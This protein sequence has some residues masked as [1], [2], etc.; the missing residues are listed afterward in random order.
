MFFLRLLAGRNCAA[1][2]FKSYQ[3]SAQ[4]WSLAQSLSFSKNY[5]VPWTS[6]YRCICIRSHTHQNFIFRCKAKPN[7]SVSVL[8]SHVVIAASTPWEFQWEFLRRSEDIYEEKIGSFQRFIIFSPFPLLRQSTSIVFKKSIHSD[9]FHS[10]F[11][12]YVL[13]L[14]DNFEWKLNTHVWNFNKI[15]LKSIKRN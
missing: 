4:I 6:L 7:D 15:A 12:N 14:L 9:E 1:A 3:P 2:Q 11:V 13:K 5:V 10:S 8:G